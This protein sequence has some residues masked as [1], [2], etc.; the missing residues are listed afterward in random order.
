MATKETEEISTNKEAGAC[1]DSQ[2]ESGAGDFLVSGYL[3]RMPNIFSR[4]VL[5]ILIL[6]L[7]AALVYSLASKIDII[8]E[9]RGVVQPTAHKSSVVADR[10]GYIE[11]I[12]ISEGEVVKA[13]AP[14]FLIRS[15]ETLTY[16]SKA[17]ELNASIPLKRES[18]NTK[19]A[20]LRDELKKLEDEH[21]KTQAVK[22]LKSE[23]TH[24]TLNSLESE[25]QF[26]RK[27]V[28]SLSKE[29]EDT[30]TLFE[31]RLIA[32]SEFNSIKS[33]LE[34][35]R[36]ELEKLLSQKSINQKESRIIEEETE[37]AKSSFVSKKKML[38]KEIRT[39]ELDRAAT[40]GSMKSE[41]DKNEHFMSVK[42]SVPPLN[43][44]AVDR[45]NCIRA[46]N[47]GTV[48]E[49]YCKTT[50][51]YVRV[52]DMLCTIVPSDGSFY[53]D[54]VV[55]NKDIGFIEPG[56][57]IKYKLDAFPYADYGT[58]KGMVVA[59]SPSAVEDKSQGFVYHLKGS[60]PQTY[61]AIKGKNYFVK[62]GMTATAEIVTEKK[63]IFSMLVG[64]LKK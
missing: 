5:Y 39:S 23:Q 43:G 37:E 42:D 1:R 6:V 38:E 53:M 40:L 18:F 63:S 14:L 15:K 17:D 29:F 4:G 13:L 30:K 61:F 3:E 64:K 12:Y 16:R 33:R 9:A 10:D 25:I 24:L 52:S 57:E 62:P 21:N 28:E 58:L 20:S 46:E 31:K 50:G 51:Q 32:I 49:L 7:V 8:V 41:L 48:S 59:V 44:S 19:I 54:V 2:L 35:S 56:A 60:L 34:K 11:R 45:E 47:A 26:W 55:A 22:R 36:T 27:E